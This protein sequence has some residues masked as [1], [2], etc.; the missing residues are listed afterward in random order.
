VSPLHLLGTESTEGDDP[1]ANRNRMRRL[2]C[3]VAMATNLIVT[4]QAIAG[5][6]SPSLREGL[7]AI[8]PILSVIYVS[9]TGLIGTY[10]FLGSQE[11]RHTAELSAIMDDPRLRRDFR[12]QKIRG[13]T[14]SGRRSH[15]ERDDTPEE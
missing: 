5:V 3:Q 2:Q 6:W 14:P 11:N 13:V 1:I 8:W 4:C 9:A 7:I 15:E 12:P 10:L